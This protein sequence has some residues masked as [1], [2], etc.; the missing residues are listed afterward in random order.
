MSRK[1][2]YILLSV[3]LLASGW[4]GVSGLSLLVALVPL[5]LLSASYG[6]SM[7]DFWR[8]AGWA[9]LTFAL[10]NAAT[11][12]WVWIATPIGPIAATIVSTFWS[13]VPF[14]LY[15]YVSKRAP[16]TLSYTLLVAAWVAAEKL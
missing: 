12:W 8:M 16:K 15:H 3:A 5:L 10:W 13:V 11:I 7:R 1:L 2:I 9:T 4:L 14:M 6:D